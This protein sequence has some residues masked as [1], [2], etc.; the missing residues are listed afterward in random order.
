[1]FIQP[2][3]PKKHTS[4][5]KNNRTARF[6]GPPFSIESKDLLLDIGATIDAD[7]GVM[8]RHLIFGICPG[9]DL[10]QLVPM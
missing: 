4:K 7:N 5:K 1:M 9:F 10:R 2:T 8:T 3:P 6:H